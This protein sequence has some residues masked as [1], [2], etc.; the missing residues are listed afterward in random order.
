MKNTPNTAPYVSQDD[1]NDMV[2][3]TIKYVLEDNIHE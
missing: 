3:R 2:N 1:N